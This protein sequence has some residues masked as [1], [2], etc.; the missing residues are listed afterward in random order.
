MKAAG[1][2]P[3]DYDPSMVPVMRLIRELAGR[4][5]LARISIDK[6]GFKLKMAGHGQLEEA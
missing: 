4:K 5:D 3:R 2:A 6:P 1:P